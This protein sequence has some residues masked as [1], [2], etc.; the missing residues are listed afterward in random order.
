MSVCHL[1]RCDA[2][3][4]PVE[5]ILEYEVGRRYAF[6]QHDVQTVRTE[7]ATSRLGPLAG[8][9][10]RVRPSQPVVQWSDL[11]RAVGEVAALLTQ[12]LRS[13]GKRRLYM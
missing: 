8:T 3:A 6:S 10:S 2:L 13:A 7:L 5:T 12:R 11:L 1:P 9:L 4:K